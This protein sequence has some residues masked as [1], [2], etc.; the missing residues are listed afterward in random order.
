MGKIPRPS[1]PYNS[2]RIPKPPI[3][4][5]GILKF[6]FKNLDLTSNSKFGIHRCKEGYFQKL[7]ERLRDLSCMKDSEFRTARSSSLKIHKIDWSTTSEKGG[8]TSLN[9][10]LRSLEAWQFEITRNEHG[11]VHGFLLGDTFFIIWVDPDHQLYE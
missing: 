8:F 2:A 3:Q 7:L 11:R 4:V 9:D 1:V 5:D 6:S 10:Q